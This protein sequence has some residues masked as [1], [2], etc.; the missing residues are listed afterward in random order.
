MT[1]GRKGITSGVINGLTLCCVWVNSVLCF[2][3]EACS[4]ERYK[5]ACPCWQ[6]RPV[7]FTHRSLPSALPTIAVCQLGIISRDPMIDIPSCQ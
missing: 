7:L 6:E 5:T 2:T 1:L 3:R 4:A